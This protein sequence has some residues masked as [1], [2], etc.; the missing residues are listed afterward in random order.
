MADILI[1]GAGM[2]GSTMAIDLARDREHHV[3][4]ADRNPHALGAASQRV[5]DATGI[6]VATLEAELTN[7]DAVG[8]L[9][10]EADILLGAL[11]SKVGYEALA[12]VVEAGTPYV[13]I[14]FMEEN[15]LDLDERA[16]EIGVTAVVDCGVA[17]GLS[18]VLAGYGVSQLD[19][20]DRVDIWV[21]GLPRERRWPFSYKA[22]FS[23]GDVLEEYTR[24]ARLVENGQVVTRE[25]LSE[26]EMVD[27]S[28]WPGLGTLEAF[29][30]D[31]LRTLIHTLDVPDM[32][33]KTLRYPGHAELMRVF[34]ETG[35]FG[36]APIEVGGARVRPIDV[37]SALLFPKWQYEEGEADLTVMRVAVEGMRNGRRM[38]LGWELFDQYDA[39][40]KCSS[41]SR[42]TAFPA[43]IVAREILAGRIVG[44]GVLPPE[45]LGRMS[46]FVETLLSELQGRGVRIEASE[47]VLSEPA[48]EQPGTTEAAP[49]QAGM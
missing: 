43:T 21:G 18:N 16:K 28:R 49:A 7:D 30:T 39:E 20:C 44:P 3:S 2:V 27:F 22:G 11:S 15:P 38:R 6:E 25:A 46:S 26:P 45:T 19:S 24:P 8:L 13:D 33:E 34:R 32:R 35:F 23:P 42:T 14:S 12:A 31:G 4:I 40:S 17:P 41:M 29:N 9:A 47:T 37:T 48:E 36:E 5:Q 10:D 1:L